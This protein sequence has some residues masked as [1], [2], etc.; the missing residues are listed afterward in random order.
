MCLLAVGSL[1]YLDKI[2]QQFA[3]F[4][5]R[6][7]ITIDLLNSLLLKFAEQTI[8]T[9]VLFFKKNVLININKR[10]DTKGC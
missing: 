10:S 8:Q 5:Y 7:R 9:N 3:N 4:K 1:K 6:S 2:Y